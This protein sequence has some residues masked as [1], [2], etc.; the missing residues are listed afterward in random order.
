MVL[1]FRLPGVV[2]KN[3]SHNFL[4][5]LM[6]KIKK[7]QNLIVYNPKAMFNNLIHV[8]NLCLIVEQILKKRVLKLT[9]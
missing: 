4:S 1:F 2:G 7:N 6:K 9:I 3:S 8:K 5:N